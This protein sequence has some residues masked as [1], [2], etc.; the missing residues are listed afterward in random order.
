M[1][2]L[3]RS[4]AAVCLLAASV[5]ATA[6]ADEAS[7]SSPD[8]TREVRPI[9][10]RHCFKCHGP[11][12]DTREAGLRLDD[13]TSAT[14]P[15]DSGETAIVPGKPDAS[16]L[17]TR[18]FS[19]DESLLMPP[20]SAKLPLTA[21]QKETL[22]R[23]IA[24]GAE[25]EQ[26]WAFQ[27]PVHGEPPAVK[28][29][30]WPHNAIDR[31]VLAKLESMDL[32]PS[33][34]AD[35]ETLAR[36]ASFDLIG[37]PPTPAEL[38]AFLADDAP[39]A[40]ERYVDRLLES[41][42]YGERW[43]RR[44]L[45]L[46]RYA[47]TNGYEK[48]RPR[49]IWPYR[50][51]VINALNA[52]M[53]F[54][55][56]TI[57]QLAGDMLPNA[58]IQQRIATGF[59]RN[60]ML[61][62][63]GGI[64]PLEFRF[65]A[66]TD[67]VQT[68]GTTW[69]GLTL[70]CA[71]CHTHKYDPLPHREYYAIMAMLNNADEPE[72]DIPTPEVSAQREQRQQ[73]IAALID[74]LLTK[75]PADGFAKWLAVERERVIRWRPLRPATAKSNLPLLTVQDDDSVFVSGDIT[76][77]DTYELT[78]AP[79]AQPITAVRLEAMP[80]D[81]L[82]AHGPGM[83]YYE[84]RKGDFFLGEFQLEAD[85]QPVKFAS[86]NHSFAKLSIGGGAVSAALTIDGDPET[87]WSTATREGEP[88]HAV[89]RLEQPLTEA[90][91]LRL[92]MLFGRHYAAS[93]GRFRIWVT[94]DPRANDAREMPAEIE[95]L[96]LLAD[97]DLNPSQA[98]PA[99]PLLPANLGGLSRRASRI[100]RLKNLPA[101]PTTLVMHERPPENPRPT[102]I[103][104]RGEFLQPTDEVQPG[105]FSSLH[106]LPP[107]VEANRLG[108]ARWLVARDNPLTSRVVVNRAWA[109]FFGLGLVRTVEDFGFQGAAPSH[110][111][112]LDYLAVE[113]MEDGWSMKRLH[114]RIV[115]SAAYRQA[116]RV[117]P[118]LLE[119]DPENVWL[120]RG[121]RVRLD[122][123]MIR[124]AALRAS[125]LLSP[126][127]GGP[128]VFPPQPPGVTTEGTYGKLNWNPSTGEDRYR[129]GLYTFSKRTA[130]FAMF[131]TFD[132]P[133][134]EACLARRDVSNTPLQ[135]LTLMNDVVFQEAAQALGQ[136]LAGHNAGGNAGQLDEDNAARLDELYRRVLSRRPNAAEQATLLGFFDAQR[137]RLEAGELD[138]AA[139]LRDAPKIAELPQVDAK[140]AAAWTLVA[141]IVLNLDEAIT[142]H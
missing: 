4:I 10:S 92:R 125:G 113:L 9:L 130:P 18:V 78:F 124:D 117:T 111:E 87:G 66:M 105:V 30:D 71:Q 34:P 140:D 21:A 40:Y 93:L 107:G 67:R 29:A 24:A 96:L 31:F 135:A 132:G 5:N 109:A 55:Q 59:H 127:L 110:P 15:A 48:D 51:W 86:A 41:P 88:H 85:G 63:E 38:D 138:A 104:K 77:T 1:H 133:T 70:Q 45:D 8:F 69:L 16:E 49:S 32:K 28:A 91:E 139:I 58:T 108:L 53:P 118:E 35:R 102:F 64:D 62:E 126:K 106:A 13:P 72:L 22:R 79:G 65:Y 142:K 98:R 25:Y 27:P 129:R 141:R 47:D 68:T 43:A 112:L 84:G 26:H 20:P 101:Y 36:R 100:D 75:A 80:D 99:S 17:L 94:D 61:N 56:F 123:E 131:T 74:K 90:G 83:T 19:D 6:R 120:A 136:R 97:A 54:D 12:P 121:P 52:D 81:R 44:W 42:R 137:G 134:G 7:T 73:Q 46:A 33:P 103:H 23:W 50:D 128:S 14:A 114:K 57:E 89:Y 76:K 115:M 122:G 3:P 119:L 37:L 2:R 82:P 39:N 60:T 116:S 11:D 95:S